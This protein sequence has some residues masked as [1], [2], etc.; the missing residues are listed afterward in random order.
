MAKISF[1]GLE[2][3]EYLSEGQKGEACHI[4]KEKGL[5]PMFSV[6]SVPYDVTSSY[7]KGASRGAKALLEAS[8]HM[9]LY[10][11]EL[12]LEPCSF[13][14]ETL[15]DLDLEGLTPEEM[16]VA[17][18]KAS[19]EI[20]ESGT[21]PVMLG[22]DHSVTT[23]LLRALKEKYEDLSVLHF[24]AHADMR[25]SYE[26]TP[27]NHAC[28]GRRIA[29]ICKVVQ[30]GVRS[31]SIEEAE[32]LKTANNVKT[33][34]AK[35]IKGRTSVYHYENIA[36]EI[37]KFLTDNIF[38]TIDLD[39]FDPSIMPATGTPEP[40][41]LEWYDVIN[42]IREVIKGKNVVGFD[43]VE[44]CP[45]DGMV[46]PDFMAAKLVYKVMGYIGVAKKC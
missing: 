33:Y 32:F 25:D 46:A 37:K 19:G 8:S 39:V 5:T 43:C 13:G 36:N 3:E 14:I 1:G 26:G 16:V 41:G 28:T 38:I 45:I 23:G 34:Y 20:I 11:E 29:D 9:E 12:D 6:F 40:G 30:V 27:Y 42:T 35:D 22:G 24:D 31:L 18:E 17:V 2:E 44:L 10:D 21:I 15:D 4:D 7:I